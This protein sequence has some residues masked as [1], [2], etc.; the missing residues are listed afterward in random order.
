MEKNNPKIIKERT[1]VNV[2]FERPYTTQ[3]GMRV[4]RLDQE[5]QSAVVKMVQWEELHPYY[6]DQKPIQEQKPKSKRI[7]PQTVKE[8]KSQNL[9]YYREKSG[10]NTDNDEINKLR[11]CDY[12]PLECKKYPLINQNRY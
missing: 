12:I 4:H 9:K 8:R 6:I 2:S 7:R 10:L 1:N 5:R 3:T 11:N